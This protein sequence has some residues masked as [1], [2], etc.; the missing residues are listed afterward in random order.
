[1]ASRTKA[2]ADLAQRSKSRVERRIAADPDLVP[3]QFGGRVALRTVQRRKR[4]RLA[5]FCQRDGDPIAYVSDSFRRHFAHR[6]RRGRALVFVA[7][8]PLSGDRYRRGI[9]ASPRS[10]PCAIPGTF[11]RSLQGTREK[12]RQRD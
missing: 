9:P 6:H 2:A 8:D 11:R 5:G 12:K 7:Y 10:A 3:R 1:M 4:R